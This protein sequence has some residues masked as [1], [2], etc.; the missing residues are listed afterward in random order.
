MKA[1]TVSELITVLQGL[2]QDLTVALEGCDCSG[3]CSGAE[4]VEASTWDPEHVS[5]IRDDERKL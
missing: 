4:V 3:S 5:L 2:P 1:I